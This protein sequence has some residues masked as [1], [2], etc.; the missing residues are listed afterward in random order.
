MF[1][2][3]FGNNNN[4]TS[5]TEIWLNLIKSMI[6][7]SINDI[8]NFREFKNNNEIDIDLEELN[9]ND[10]NEINVI[11]FF[12]RR[13][14]KFAV[15]KWSFSIIKNTEIHTGMKFININKINKKL[16]IMKK[17][18]LCLL[19]MLPLYQLYKI[20]EKSFNINLESKIEINQNNIKIDENNS[21]SF[22]IEPIKDIFGTFNLNISYILK[23]T[24]FKIED[25]LNQN[26]IKE[27][28]KLRLASNNKD[29]NLSESENDSSSNEIIIDF[30]EKERKEIENLN[31]LYL[32]IQNFDI[33][34]KKEN[35]SDF[36]F[37]DDYISINEEKNIIED[38]YDNKNENENQNEI[39]V[40][41]IITP[42]NEKNVFDNVYNKF[43]KLKNNANILYINNAQLNNLKDKI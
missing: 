1:K 24:I 42:N 13:R 17:S 28:S 35:E 15:E 32:K 37:E 38:Y 23:N 33:E 34:N 8:K 16:L 10:K 22:L 12:S 4:S 5:S 31:K 2:N 18:I 9:N 11:I 25:E 43:F 21:I 40:L 36:S 39:P 26:I 6:I 19:K 41:S 30:I 29:Y 20:K 3:N 27:D 7:N 14:I